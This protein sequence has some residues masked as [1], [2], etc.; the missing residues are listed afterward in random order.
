MKGT[1]NFLKSLIGIPMGIFTLELLNIMISIQ[2]GEYIRL[3]SLA[4]G[5]NLKSVLLTYIYCSIYSYIIMTAINYMLDFAEIDLTIK[6]RKRRI[7]KI[8]LPL[9]ILGL[10]NNN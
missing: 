5:I 2:Q 1:K 7:N 10:L 6:E 9:I 3:D 8:A 4:N